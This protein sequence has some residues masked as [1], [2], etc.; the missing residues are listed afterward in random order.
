MKTAIVLGST[1]LIGSELVRLLTA[2][3]D[4]SSVLL[5]NRR[6]SGLSHPKVS[7]KIIDFDAPDLSGIVGD[8]LYIAFGTTLRKAGSQ[9]A[10]QRIDAQ[11]PTA[12]A[13]GLKKQG[14]KRVFLVSSVG[15][16]LKA[17]AF[18][19]RTKGQ[20]EQAII[21]LGFAQTV[22]AR[23]S[24]LLGRTG[25]FRFGEEAAMFA[26]KLFSPLMIGSLKKYR[27]I[28]ANQVARSLV[29][30]A[31]SESPGIQLLDYERMQQ[32]K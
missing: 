5:L 19:I 15:A 16:D 28:Q 31:A 21:A 24:F 11:Y 3:P 1:G 7:E 9:A 32:L 30:A 26:M 25:E 14:I 6:P 29:H 27:A 10:L 8:D 20:L 13:T 23:P 2:S 22:I 17:K 18:Y 12:I 4:Y